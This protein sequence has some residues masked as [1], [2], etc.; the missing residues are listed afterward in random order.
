[1]NYIILSTLLDCVCVLHLASSVLRLCFNFFFLRRV[2]V[3]LCHTNGSRALFIGLTN[4]FFQQLFIE[5]G[6]YDTIHTFKNYFATVFSVFSGIQTDPECELKTWSVCTTFGMQKIFISR[7]ILYLILSKLKWVVSHSC[8]PNT[9]CL[10]N[11][12]SRLV[13]VNLPH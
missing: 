7:W 10:L 13:Q 9:T 8:Q 1:M 12:S 2:S 4:L 6:S 5:N 11:V 3:A